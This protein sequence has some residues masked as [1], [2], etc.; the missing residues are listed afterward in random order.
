MY[1]I[2]VNIAKQLLSLYEDEQLLV[3]YPVSTSAYGIGNREASLKTPLGHHRVCEK[4][5]DDMPADEVFIGRIP[6]GRLADLRQQERQLPEDIIT[7]RILRLVG[8]E[9][10]V[11]RGEGIDSF[12]RY[13]YI[14]GT[15]DEERISEPVSHGC[16]R[17]R[18]DDIIDL[19]NKIELDT[20]VWIEA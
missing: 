8:M 15:S 4:I 18:N 2:T 13:I 7:A 11:N 10:G 20:D 5:G 1:S 14:H 3:E 19:F 6:Q 9:P 16:I 17:M 12:Q